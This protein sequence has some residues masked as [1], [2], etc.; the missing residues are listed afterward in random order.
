MGKGIGYG[1]NP[2][3]IQ[4]GALKVDWWF[5]G[6]PWQLLQLNWCQMA[7]SHWCSQKGDSDDWATQ[8][9]HINYPGVCP[10]EVT[11]ESLFSVSTQHG[12]LVD[13]GYKSN[14]HRHR[15]GWET[16]GDTIIVHWSAT[17]RL[18]P[19]Q[20]HVG[21]D[22][23]ESACLFALHSHTRCCSTTTD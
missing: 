11:P 8:G 19:G 10:T 15:G 3:E 1:V 23:P 4:S 2:T 20:L 6:C 21:A 22:L 18:K 12:R 16:V 7:C 9:L 5:N 17:A 14:L 13:T